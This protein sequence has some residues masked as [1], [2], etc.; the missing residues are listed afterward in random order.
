MTAKEQLRE[1]IE[2]LSE[3][4][5]SQALRL[6]DLRDDPLVVAFRDA[7]AD[8]EPVTAE[9]EAAIAEARGDVAAGR[10]ISLEDALRE[11]E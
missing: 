7:P 5:A 1:R 9:D 2:A 10:T 3:E 6:L 11:S 8:D 4:E